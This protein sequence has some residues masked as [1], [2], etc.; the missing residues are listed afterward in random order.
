MSWFMLRRA[1]MKYVVW[2]TG[3][4][5][6]PQLFNLTADPNEW[7]NLAVHPRGDYSALVTELDTLLKTAID[8]PEVARDV[9]R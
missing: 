8:Y 3:K 2:G 9:A 7:I 6:P 4:E 5:H 1:E